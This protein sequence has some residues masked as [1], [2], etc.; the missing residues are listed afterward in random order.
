MNEIIMKIIFPKVIPHA[1][2]INKRYQTQKIK[3]KLLEIFI[4]KTSTKHDFLI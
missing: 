2:L 4:M 1:T 3:S